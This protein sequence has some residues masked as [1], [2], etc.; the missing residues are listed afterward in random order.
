[1]QLGSLNR[2]LLFGRYSVEQRR[3]TGDADRF[4]DRADL[5]R[6]GL[7]RLLARGQRDSL[8]L[9]RLESLRLDSQVVSSGW[10]EIEYEFARAVGYFAI[11]NARLRIRHG[12]RGA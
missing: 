12:N 9:V 6:I 11:N 3:R 1:P 10:K 8:R 2:L 4:A 5:E 7:A